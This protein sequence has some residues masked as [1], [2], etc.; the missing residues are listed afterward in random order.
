MG[1]RPVTTEVWGA[2]GLSSVVSEAGGRGIR[3]SRHII[4]Q[5]AQ[6]I[7]KVALRGGDVR[8]AQR[9]LDAAKQRAQADEEVPAMLLARSAIVLARQALPKGRRDQLHHEGNA[10]AFGIDLALNAHAKM[11][12]P[13]NPV[14]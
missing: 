11:E 3:L 13:A 1:M 8:R 14:R 10:L 4:R 9:C 12:Q 7:R 2:L 6:Y 5:A